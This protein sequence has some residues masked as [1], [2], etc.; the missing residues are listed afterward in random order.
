MITVTLLA[1]L[2]SSQTPEMWTAYIAHEF[3]HEWTARVV[4]RP[5][6]R[7]LL[8]G[9]SWTDTQK[10]YKT[11]AKAGLIG[12][13]WHS[14]FFGGANR[15]CGSLGDLIMTQFYAIWQT[16]FDDF[17]GRAG[18]YSAFEGKQF[19]FRQKMALV[20]TLTNYFQFGVAYR[21]SQ[22]NAWIDSRTRQAGLA[23]AR[24]LANLRLYR[25]R[26]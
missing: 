8:G 22:D 1:L 3:A 14:A 12:N 25:S 6:H 26:K 9:K 20:T 11:I 17:D 5:T 21:A 16:K 4:D 15:I 2:C 23:S 10:N 24:G 18:D 7:F 13:I 19:P